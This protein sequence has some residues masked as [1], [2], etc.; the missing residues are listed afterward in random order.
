[1]S[2]TMQELSSKV[3]QLAGR[4]DKKMDE[5]SDAVSQL[6]RMQVELTQVAKGNEKRDTVVERLTERVIE[7]E[8]VTSVNSLALGKY[9]RFIWVIIAAGVGLIGKFLL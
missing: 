5:L 7:L 4:F 6:V 8:K 2:T 3:D 1:M 9:E